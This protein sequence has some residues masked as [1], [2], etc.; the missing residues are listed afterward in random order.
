M[1][2][3]ATVR[4]GADLLDARLEADVLTDAEVIGVG[5]EVA[6]DLAARRIVG[7][8]GGEGEVGEGRG[9][10][11]R[12][13]MQGAVG[14]AAA[15]GLRCVKTPD[16][17]QVRRPLE[18]GGPQPLIQQAPGRREAARAAADDRYIPY[19]APCHVAPSRS[20]CVLVLCFPLKFCP[21][22]WG[23]VFCV[24]GVTSFWRC[25]G[26]VV[27]H[28]LLRR[29]CRRMR[30]SNSRARPYDPLKSVH[31]I[32]NVLRATGMPV[33][34]TFLSYRFLRQARDC[35]AMGATRYVCIMRCATA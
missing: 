14:R 12:V 25:G 2:D 19:S 35:P 21:T 27:S 7:Q 16:P 10:L 33:A 23:N 34:Y 13:G 24:L 18:H 9:L 4:G 11:G 31:Y 28:T 6:H 32:A 15:V 22:N 26:R 30:M 3:P 5:A 20:T 8:T 1:H 17:A 29:L